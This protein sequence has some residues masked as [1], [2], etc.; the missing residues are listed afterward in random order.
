MA[1]A[2]RRATEQTI[3]KTAAYFVGLHSGIEYPTLV[4]F[5]VKDGAI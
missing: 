5:S 3:R 1:E 4:G 2:E